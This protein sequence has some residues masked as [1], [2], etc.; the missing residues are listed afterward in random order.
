MALIVA[1][2]A[3]L[4]TSLVFQVKAITDQTG[5]ALAIL[6]YNLDAVMAMGGSASRD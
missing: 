6:F 4:H 1:T 5:T 2:V 3:Y